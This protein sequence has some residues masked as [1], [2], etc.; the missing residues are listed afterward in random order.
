MSI[1]INKIN[2]KKYTIKKNHKAKESAGW[3]RL[4]LL[5]L[6]AQTPLSLG[7]IVYIFR[8][9]KSLGQNMNESIRKVRPPSS[10]LKIEP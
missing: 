5:G 10:G 9:G 7:N 2:N 3:F 1:S 6:I 4:L 8:K